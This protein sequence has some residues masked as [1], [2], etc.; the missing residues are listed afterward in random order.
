MKNFTQSKWIQSL[1]ETEWEKLGETE[2]VNVMAECF[3]ANVTKALDIC[4]PL[5]TITVHSKHKF[6]LSE[7]TKALMSE[8]DNIRKKMYKYSSSERKV[9][10][11]KYR[12]LRNA[13]TNQSRKDTKLYNEER[14]EKAADQKEIWKV[15]NDVISPQV[16]KS[17]TLNE[18]GKII[19]D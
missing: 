17:L 15:V 13:A 19:E 12:K 7:N 11:L 18:D 9:F 10:H 5:K 16:K 4:A 2:D 1:V 6:G 14:I 8:R 3:N